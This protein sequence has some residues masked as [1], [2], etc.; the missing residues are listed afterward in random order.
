MNIN[1]PS[2]NTLEFYIRNC[3]ETE[4]LRI[5]RRYCYEIKMIKF[6]PDTYVN[7]KKLLEEIG[8]VMEKMGY[9]NRI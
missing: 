7:N 5:F 2:G 8:R 9:R 4:R 6:D 1:I 3:S